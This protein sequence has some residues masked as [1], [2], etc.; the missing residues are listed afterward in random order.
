MADMAHL[1]EPVIPALRRYARTFVRDAAGADDL[2]QDT[3]ERAIRAV[4]R[5]RR[6]SP[7]TGSSRRAPHGQALVSPSADGSS[8]PAPPARCKKTTRLDRQMHPAS[9]PPTI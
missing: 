7:S 4:L 3:L 9:P 1:I 6:A 5:S 2:V 8:A